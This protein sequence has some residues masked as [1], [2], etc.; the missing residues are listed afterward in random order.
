MSAS[1]AALPEGQPVTLYAIV[2]SGPHCTDALAGLDTIAHDLRTIIAGQYCAV[3]SRSSAPDLKGRS[4]EDLGRFLIVHQKVLEQLMRTACVLP[5]QFGTRMPDKGIRELLEQGCC[6]FDAIFSELR[7]CTQLEVSV[8]WDIDAVLAEIAGQE[9]VVRLKAQIADNAQGATTAARL[10]LGR[11]VKAELERRR[12]ALAMHI[13]AVLRAM[14]IDAIACPVAAD[15]VVLHLVLLL[16]MNALGEVDRC[17]ETLDAAYGGGL[18]FRCV[19]PMP[20]ANFATLAVDLLDGDEL[21][22]AGR[23]LG[24][25]LTAGLDDVRS[26][27]RRLARAA[28][29]DAADGGNGNAGAMAALSDAYRVL[30]RYVRARE[31]DRRSDSEVAA[32]AMCISIRRQDAQSGVGPI[33]GKR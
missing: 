6:L 22:H 7:D 1:R 12:E 33:P 27:Y 25:A 11:L 8:T 21:E 15:R 28:H 26:A 17:V 29:P 30:A 2:P 4:R 9:A 23:T 16:K 20:P 19:G 32:R 31:V 13:L 14:A 24:V 3:V 5:V 18:C 10:E